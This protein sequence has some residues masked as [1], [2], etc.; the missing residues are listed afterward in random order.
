M[1]D[2]HLTDSDIARVIQE[3]KKRLIRDVLL[4]SQLGQLIHDSAAACGFQFSP[5]FFGGLRAFVGTYLRGIVER[6]TT[7]GA[8]DDVY[9]VLAPTSNP[10][11]VPPTWKRASGD[12]A[13]FW[14]CFSNPTKAA[15]FGLNQS[16]EL[17]LFKA[18]TIL[19]E[20][21]KEL[22]QMT[23]ADYF[24]MAKKYI[25][26][27]RDQNVTF[28]PEEIEQ[29][30]AESFYPKWYAMLRKSPDKEAVK[31]WEIYRIR[32]VIDTL[33]QY[34]MATGMPESQAHSYGLM[35]KTSQAVSQRQQRISVALSVPETT[36]VKLDYLREI[37][38]KVTRDLTIEQM[39]QLTLPLGIVIDAISDSESSKGIRR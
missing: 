29:L 21:W 16:Q 8:P 35:L 19:P 13:T 31:K 33:I 36:P 5:Q 14:Q 10:D 32:N 15:T 11:A 20:G 12:D 3:L 27:L 22:Q 28:P 18:S 1:T 34:L 9:T 24:R 26:N 25:V 4:G 38:A 2:H 6:D 39:R 7:A 30:G 23:A 37:V 17:W